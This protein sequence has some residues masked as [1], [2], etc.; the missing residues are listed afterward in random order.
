M[1]H[2][3]AHKVAFTLREPTLIRVVAPIHR[4]LEF[5]LVLNQDQGPYSHKTV[6]RAKREDY[7]S[8]VFA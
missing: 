7:H 2:N 1:W 6:I 3:Q 8:T 5:E 4:H